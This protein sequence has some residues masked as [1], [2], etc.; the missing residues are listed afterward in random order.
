VGDEFT[1]TVNLQTDVAIA[2]VRAQLRFDINAF[3]YVS[4]D[5]GDLVAS[6]TDAKVGNFAGGAQIDATAASDQPLTGSGELMTLKFKALRVQPQAAFA[7]VVTAMN[8]AGVTTASSS[9][10]PLMMTI[11]EP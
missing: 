4:G 6:A 1:V 10:D 11:K 5:P 9:P 7:A 8:A 2:R 3:Q